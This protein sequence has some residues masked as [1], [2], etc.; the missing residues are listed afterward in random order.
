MAFS[1]ALPSSLLLGFAK[2]GQW[3]QL[4]KLFL[5]MTQKGMQPLPTDLAKISQLC[6]ENK[7]LETLQRIVE[8]ATEASIQ[9]P[10][11]F[12]ENSLD[13]CRREPN[14]TQALQLY[15]S[16]KANQE[17]YDSVCE[18]IRSRCVHRFAK[19]RLTVVTANTTKERTAGSAR[20]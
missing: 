18:Q 15:D 8:V 10:T 14:W 5:T 17:N 6:F 7:S 12:Y 1:H 11:A 4:L 20:S 13:M 19:M 3:D 2:K 9:L 16:F